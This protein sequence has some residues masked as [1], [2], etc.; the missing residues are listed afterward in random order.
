MHKCTEIY[1]QVSSTKYQQNIA[2]HSFPID[3][4]SS[5]DP[6]YDLPM[7]APRPVQNTAD[8][9]CTQQ[10]CWGEVWSLISLDHTG[11]HVCYFS[12]QHCLHAWMK[13]EK[14][15]QHISRH[16]DAELNR[17]ASK[18]LGNQSWLWIFT[19]EDRAFEILHFALTQLTKHPALPCFMR[20]HSV[21]WMIAKA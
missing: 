4:L 9:T 2:T 8:K 16:A 7:M 17:I 20:R 3:F 5:S 11:A 14:H 21:A 1:T 19:R 6:A 15:T 10:Y 18:V 12:T 13:E